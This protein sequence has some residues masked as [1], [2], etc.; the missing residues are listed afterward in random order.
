MDDAVCVTRMRDTS[1]DESSIVSSDVI[2]D[3]SFFSLSPEFSPL[4][5]VLFANFF[6]S[7]EVVVF[8]CGFCDKLV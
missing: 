7:L 2:R 3:A 5:F 4:I 1:I 6:S 8:V